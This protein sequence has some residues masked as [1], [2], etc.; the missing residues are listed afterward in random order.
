MNTEFI[1]LSYN[2]SKLLY[3]YSYERKRLK[4]Y[5]FARGETQECFYPSGK[6][7][8][9]LQRD[10]VLFMNVKTTKNRKKIM[11]LLMIHE[12]LK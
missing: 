11:K 5:S 3:G 9:E 4:A 8:T 12:L 1:A 10:R 2:S 6:L 7:N